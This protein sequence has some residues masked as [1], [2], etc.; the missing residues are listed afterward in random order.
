MQKSNRMASYGN[1]S[2]RSRARQASCL[3]DESEVRILF[4]KGVRGK[5]SVE[6]NTGGCPIIASLRI[7]DDGSGKASGCPYGP[8]GDGRRPIFCLRSSIP[9]IRGMRMQSFSAGMVEVVQVVSPNKNP[10]DFHL[11][12]QVEIDSLLT[13]QHFPD[14]VDTG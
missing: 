12:P 3:P 13:G 11:I 5:T 6:R 8:G 9:E 1:N 7:G 2:S 4:E 10:L 14:L